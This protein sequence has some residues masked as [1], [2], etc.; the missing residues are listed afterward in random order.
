MEIDV[1]KISS[2]EQLEEVRAALEERQ[3]ELARVKAEK[4]K[5]KKE[6]GEDLKVVTAIES[7]RAKAAKLEQEANEAKA[8]AD[9]KI[10]YLVDKYGSRVEILG[11]KKI[12]V[13]KGGGRSDAL[14]SV[15]RVLKDAKAGMKESEIEEKTGLESVTSQLRRLRRL[16]EASSDKGVWY[17]EKD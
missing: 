12:E 1:E 5:V 2:E 9:G 17:Y 16:G 4:E 7:L 15:R 10:N 8:E 3:K 11:I 13:R 6:L 14:E